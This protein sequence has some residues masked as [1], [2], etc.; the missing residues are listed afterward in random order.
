MWV[1]EGYKLE[2]SPASD[3]ELEG[4]LQAAQRPPA[5]V[6]YSAHLQAR[7]LPSTACTESHLRQGSR[8]EKKRKD[9]GFWHQF[10]EKPRIILGCPAD[11]A[12]HMQLAAVVVAV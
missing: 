1:S 11:K 3:D 9:Y 5:N 12:P 7:S 4:P 8:E 2:E 10:N 6:H